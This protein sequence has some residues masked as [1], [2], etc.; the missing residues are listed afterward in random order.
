MNA[1]A[2]RRVSFS[3]L[4][5]GVALALCGCAALALPA[6]APLLGGGASGAVKAGTEYAKNG[7]VYRTFSLPFDQAHDAM[8]ETLQRWH[9]V[10]ARAGGGPAPGAPV[11]LLTVHFFGSGRVLVNGSPVT[12]WRHKS[13]RLFKYL[14]AHRQHPVLREQLLDL[15]WPEADPAAARNCLN[16]TLHSVRRCLA[17]SCPGGSVDLILFVGRHYRL[18]PSLQ[19]WADTDAFDEYIACARDAVHGSRSR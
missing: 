5:L 15:F 19:V 2:L 17:A 13:E 11:L 9:Q 10:G 6:L 1:L 3:A 16:V 14:V 18:H 12:G 8:L 4:T 7:T